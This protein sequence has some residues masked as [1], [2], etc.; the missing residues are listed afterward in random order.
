VAYLGSPVTL[1][2]EAIANLADRTGSEIKIIPIADKSYRLVSHP[3]PYLDRISSVPLVNP[4]T[5]E[6]EQEDIV[7]PQ[8]YTSLKAADQIDRI[9]TLLPV[10]YATAPAISIILNRCQMAKSPLSH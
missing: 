3:E 7:K 6:Q 1:S 2:P 5:G 8:P 9:K 4:T 10:P